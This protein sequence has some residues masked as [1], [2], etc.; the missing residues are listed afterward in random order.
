MQEPVLVSPDGHEVADLADALPSGRFVLGISGAPGAGKSTLARALATAYGAPVVPMDG[1]HRTTADLVARGRLDAKGAP[2]TFDAEAYAALLRR[3]H[4]GGDVLAPSFEHGQPDPRADTIPVPGSAGLVLTEGNYLLL[5]RPEWRPVR[6]ELDA[7]W[8]VV[9][10]DAVRLQ[11]LVA[12]HVAAGRAPSH[13][14]AWVERV[15]QPNATLVEAAATR[16]DV[17]LDLSAW[18]GRLE[19]GGPRR[20]S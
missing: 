12:R 4:C 6:L 3:L 5:D 15:D 14:E 10:D 13:A 18:S 8:H 1:F 7:V 17:V 19:R 2:D 9:T 16:A 20:R 11:R